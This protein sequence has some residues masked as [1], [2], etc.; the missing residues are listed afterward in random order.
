[1]RNEFFENQWRGLCERLQ[2]CARELP[3][4]SNL[5]AQQFADQP[6]PSS[7]SELLERVRDAAHKAIAWQGSDSSVSADSTT[8]EPSSGNEN[9]PRPR[10]EMDQVEESIDES[11]PASDPPSWNSS[12]A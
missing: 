1:M 3:G 12:H 10:E 2:Q 6:P 8:S 5:E 4:D 7:Y 11:F 9:E